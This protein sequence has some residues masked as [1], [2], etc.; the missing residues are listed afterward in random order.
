MND[1]ALGRL[2]RTRIYS[3]KAEVRRQN[4]TCPTFA[5]NVHWMAD[6]SPLRA[7][8]GRAWEHPENCFG[9]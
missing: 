5:E 2:K 3:M 7:C 6:F 4:V 1:V 8:L 9:R